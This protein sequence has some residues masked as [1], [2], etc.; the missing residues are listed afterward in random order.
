MQSL[1][2]VHQHI[3]AFDFKSENLLSFTIL[4]TIVSLS[5]PG[6]NHKHLR[7]TTDINTDRDSLK[8]RL[9]ISGNCAAFNS[10]ERLAQAVYTA[11]NQLI[12]KTCKETDSRDTRLKL[13]F[14]L[15]IA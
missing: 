14:S 7:D 11:V 15:F 12:N 3:N 9:E 1:L 2:E 10:S 4:E 5:Q 6:L 13:I 8:L